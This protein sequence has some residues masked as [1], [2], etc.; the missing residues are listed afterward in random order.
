VEMSIHDS[1]VAHQSSI[2]LFELG[3]RFRAFCFFSITTAYL[4]QIRSPLRLVG[5]GIDYLLQAS[6]AIDG[7]GFFVHGTTSMRPSGY[8]T[9]IFIL[10]KLGI[11]DARAIVALNCLFLAIG[12]WAAYHLIRATFSFPPS[13][14]QFVIV[15]TL[16]SFVF[17]RN[18]TYPLSDVCF[19]GTSTLCLLIAEKASRDC[20]WIHRVSLIALNIPV[21]LLA[22]D[23]RTIGIALIPP[24]LLSSVGG[25]DAAK[26]LYRI[27]RIPR[28]IVFFLLL[29][30]CA[31]AAHT[32][33]HSRYYQFNEPMLH[34]RGIARSLAAN[35]RDHSREWGELIINLP[36]SRLP[37]IAMFPVRFIGVLALTTWIVGLWKQK[38]RN[39]VWIYS[40]GYGIIVLLY[41]W[42]DTRLWLPVIPF[43]FSQLLATAS[44][45]IPSKLIGK[46]TGLYA[47]YFCLVGLLALGYSTRLTF[48]GSKFPDL[49]GDGNLRSSYQFVMSGHAPKSG[50]IDEDAVYLLKRF[51][52]RIIHVTEQ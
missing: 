44:E 13:T 9:L 52:H 50:P 33:L 45:F 51:D 11:Q 43:V 31:L 35:L 42:Y 3:I 32:L 23:I 16:L 26:R 49:Y 29:L 37:E 22:I 27:L 17:V 2:A 1:P 19:F 4:A 48:A 20:S 10:A 14:T 7:K 41:P 25:I 12:C 24:F 39:T 21:L 30:I 47:G 5:D 40:I 38:R 15:L 18:V 36:S 46:L 28:T 34:N 8:P 6:S